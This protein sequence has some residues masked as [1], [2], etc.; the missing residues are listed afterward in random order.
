MGTETMI[1]LL[2][3]LAFTAMW[4]DDLRCEAYEAE[5]MREEENEEQC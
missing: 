1:C 2:V 5:A 3:T 4:L